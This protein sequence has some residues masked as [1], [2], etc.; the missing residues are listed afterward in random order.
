MSVMK[1][2]HAGLQCQADALAE[3]WPDR[4]WPGGAA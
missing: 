4:A 3:G 1:S 2:G